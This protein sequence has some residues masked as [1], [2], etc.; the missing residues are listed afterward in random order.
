MGQI[1]WIHDRGAAIVKKD[2]VT[3]QVSGIAED[4]THLKLENVSYKKSAT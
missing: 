1:R 4:V 3:V 2:G